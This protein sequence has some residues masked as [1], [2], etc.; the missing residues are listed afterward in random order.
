M[1]EITGRKRR[2]LA[3]VTIGV[4]T[5]TCTVGLGAVL[6]WP[7]PADFWAGLSLTVLA[8]TL[9]WLTRTT[10]DSFHGDVAAT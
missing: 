10:S 9:A 6:S 8:A 1:V 5:L 2:S 4:A 7:R 3:F